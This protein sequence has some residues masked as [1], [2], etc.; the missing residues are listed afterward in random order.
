MKTLTVPCRTTLLVSFVLSW[1]D[2]LVGFLDGVLRRIIAL[3]FELLAV[4]KPF[5][6]QKTQ[7]SLANVMTYQ[8]F[9]SSLVALALFRYRMT[10]CVELF[11]TYLDFA[12]A[13]CPIGLL[14]ELY[15]GDEVAMG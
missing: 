15:A 9:W 10:N 1:N 12:V 2:V 13:T 3:P 14:L 6:F 8:A 11:Q 4:L 7:T 5:S